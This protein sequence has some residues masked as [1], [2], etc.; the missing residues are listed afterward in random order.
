[1]AIKATIMSGYAVPPA[2]QPPRPTVTAP[3]SADLGVVIAKWG[4]PY[5]ETSEYGWLGYEYTRLYRDSSLYTRNQIEGA[6]RQALTDWYAKVADWVSGQL[7]AKEPGP[8][9]VA[10][11]RPAWFA[12][13]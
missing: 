13:P 5:D 3:V 7:G 10:N 1:M 4:G 12:D 9:P 6:Q 11:M 2:P 8:P